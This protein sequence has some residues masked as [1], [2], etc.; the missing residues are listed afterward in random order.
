MR[1]LELQ[2][3]SEFVYEALTLSGKK[4]NG[5]Y[6]GSFKDFQKYLK[7]QGLT[8]LSYKEKKVKLKKGQFKDDDF[9]SIVEE[10]Y[11]LID[12]GVKVDDALKLLI[13]SASKESSYKFLSFV[14]EELKKGSQLSTAIKE[15]SKEVGYK[16]SP[17]YISILSSGEEIGNVAYSLNTLKEFIDFK[18]TTASEVKQALS[19]PLFLIGMSVLMVF[20]VFIV[21]V[22]KFTE[23]FSADE[24][25]KIPYISQL[26]LK[27]GLF[28]NEN[29]F[30]ILGGLSLVVVGIFLYFKF[31]DINFTKFLYKIPYLK[32]MI[33]ELELSRAFN[34]M[35]MMIKGGV[36]I[37]KALKQSIS[38][39]SI[40]ELKS[41]FVEGLSELKKGRR[42]SEVF[43]ATSI[44]PPN[45][46]SM[47]SVGETSATMGEVSLSLSQR[48]LQNFKIK[49]K[50]VL[51]LLE[52][53]IVVFMGL[54]IAIIV[55]S[56]MLAVISIND[57]AM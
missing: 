57:I 36:E 25:D 55:V 24:M 23:M 43:A 10:L 13:K 22:P 27:T 2:N 35:G 6:A 42:L 45:V 28:V 18:L 29:L 26:V 50:K 16:I 32:E 19:Y 49:T 4:I 7:S 52:P 56:I 31:S 1:C 46:V 47:M 20:F 37:D 12:S 39:F 21:V 33:I 48:F 54:F 41:I 34:S 53:V 14:L 11:Y 44:I 38:L 3:K 51:S 5:R 17:L 9:A 40:D 30:L 8:L 15:A